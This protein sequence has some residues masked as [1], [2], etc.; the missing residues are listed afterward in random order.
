MSVAA[1]AGWIGVMQPLRALAALRPAAQV[2]ADDRTASMPWDQP[3]YRRDGMI[4]GV[5]TDS[6]GTLV[7]G[8]EIVVVR[9]STRREFKTLADGDGRYSFSLPQ[10]TYTVKVSLSGF[11]S[12]AVGGVKVAQRCNSVVDHTLLMAIIGE[13]II[14]PQ[15]PVPVC[16][17]PTK[18]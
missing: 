13:R 17:P 10:G 5:I 8:A 16:R 9:E 2:G 12:F 1:L 11:E 4:S 7:P 15:R 3:W 18:R 14:V 6:S